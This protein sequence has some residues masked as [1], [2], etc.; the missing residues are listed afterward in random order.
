[1]KI[2]VYT[3]PDCPP[4]QFVKNFLKEQQ[5]DFHEKDIKKDNRAKEELINKYK[6]F[7]T[8]VVIVDDKVITSQQLNELPSILKL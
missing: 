6:L 3:Q 7:S 1:L 5:I 2:I 4:C 8:P